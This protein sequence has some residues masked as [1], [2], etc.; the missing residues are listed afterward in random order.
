[1]LSRIKRMESE[2][3]TKEYAVLLKKLFKLKIKKR[4]G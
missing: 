1:V 4:M 2:G 3:A